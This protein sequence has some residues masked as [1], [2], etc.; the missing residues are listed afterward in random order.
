MS[1]WFWEGPQNQCSIWQQDSQQQVFTSWWWTRAGEL[2]AKHLPCYF[3][4]WVYQIVVKSLH[5]TWR[6]LLNEDACLKAQRPPSR[7]LWSTLVQ[8]IINDCFGLNVKCASGWV[9]GACPYH[10]AVCARVGV[11]KMQHPFPFSFFTE[12]LSVVWY[13]LADQHFLIY[14]C[15]SVVC[16]VRTGSGFFAQDIGP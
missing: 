5:K 6:V 14:D 9:R 7:I 4:S 2:G 8:D 13:I 16:S 1:C 12:W 15:C 3:G 11:D 10:K